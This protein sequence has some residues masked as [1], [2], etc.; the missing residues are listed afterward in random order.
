MNM[1]PP[2]STAKF[3]AEFPVEEGSVE[4]EVV[5]PDF[6]V[7]E[8]VVVM[9]TAGDDVGAAVTRDSLVVDESVSSSVFSALEEDDEDEKEE[10]VVAVAA[11]AVSATVVV[12]AAILP[13]GPHPGK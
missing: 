2:I 8:V 5:F 1:I 3:P 4:E 11:E 12:V 9:E 10:K 7:W 13:L 6:E